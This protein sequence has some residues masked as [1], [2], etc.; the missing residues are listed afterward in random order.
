MLDPTDSNLEIHRQQFSALH[1]KLYFNYGGQ[2][3]LP[4]VAL[5]AILESY[6]LLQQE[7]PFLKKRWISLP[8]KLR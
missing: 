3:P 2:G 5:N 4:Q 6:T 1:N 8:P 7:G